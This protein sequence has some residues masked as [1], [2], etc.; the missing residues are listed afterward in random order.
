M[1]DLRSIEGLWLYSQ[2][3]W[4]LRIQETVLINH[5]LTDRNYKLP[6]N[7]SK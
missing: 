3:T 5:A 7:F 2:M 4:L 1:L 6:W